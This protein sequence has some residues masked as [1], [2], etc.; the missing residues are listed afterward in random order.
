MTCCRP[1]RRRMAIP[2][3]SASMPNQQSPLLPSL[4][5]KG[6]RTVGVSSGSRVAVFAPKV[7]Q[8]CVFRPAPGDVFAAFVARGC[9]RYERTRRR[10]SRTAQRSLTRTACGAPPEPISES[11]MDRVAQRNGRMQG[12]WRRTVAGP[13]AK[14]ANAADARL[15]AQPSGAGS[16]G[17]HGVVA[18]RVLAR[19]MVSSPR[20]A[21]HPMRPRRDHR[22]LRDRF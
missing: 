12:G 9:R 4:L 1:K 7:T 18:A 6:R 16:H 15:F 19:A 20:L 17:A 11:P 10:G 3:M 13:T 22:G 5:P 2:G 8:R 14:P 21:L